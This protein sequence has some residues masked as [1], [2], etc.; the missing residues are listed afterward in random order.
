MTYPKT[1]LLHKPPG[2]TPLQAIE[3]F[4][5]KYPEYEHQTL[6]Y[7][8]RLDPMAEGLLLVLVNEENKK[9]HE[10][11]QL[12]KVYEFE[13][14]LGFSTDTYD[15]M[16]CIVEEKPTVVTPSIDI[17][18][19]TWVN[20]FLGVQTLSYPSYSSKPVHGHP[21]YWY[22]KRNLLHTIEIPQQSITIDTFTLISKKLYPAE[23]LYT[24][25]EQRLSVVQ[26]N[27][28]QKEIMKQWNKILYQSKETFSVYKCLLSCRSGTYV[29]G[30]V[31]QLSKDLGIPM[32]TFSIKRISIG[33][34]L[35]F[36]PSVVSLS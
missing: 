25:I 28:R 27:F 11:E 33:N 10:Y 15:V 26:G 8:G 6:S 5:N 18:I 4:K 20:A 24:S 16:G 29:R 14:L 7:A 19:Q 13:I 36:Q 34:H 23:E 3:L 32:L 21:L 9:R 30:I 17:S 35:L 2:L 31:N 12:S 22:A 1:L